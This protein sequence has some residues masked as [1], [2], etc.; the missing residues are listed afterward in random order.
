[1]NKSIKAALLSALV[2]PGAGHF[3]L[4]KYPVCLALVGAFSVPLYLVLS[5]LVEKT[6]VVIA[7]IQNGEIPLNVPAISEAITNLISGTTEQEL[8]IKVYVMIIVWIIAALDA[9]RIG[10]IKE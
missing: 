5:E 10:H 2:Y 8:T 7:Q 1:M 3:F 4:K 6:N 9:Y